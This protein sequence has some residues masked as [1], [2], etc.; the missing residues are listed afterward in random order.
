MAKVKYISAEELKSLLEK[1]PS[2][3]VCDIRGS[4]EYNSG[5]IPNAVNLP[6]GS[7]ER[8]F[9]SEI[10]DKESI[11]FHCLSGTRTRMNEAKLM[12][13]PFKNIYIL[14]NGINEWKNLAVKSAVLEVAAEGC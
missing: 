3:T 9:F 11:V 6:I 13:A 5:H 2:L 14:K 4:G 10:K 1:K 7:F 8:A 12:T